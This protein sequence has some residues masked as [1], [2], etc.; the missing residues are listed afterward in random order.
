[1]TPNHEF[2]PFKVNK[3]RF[4][5]SLQRVLDEEVVPSPVPGAVTFRQE[6]PHGLVLGWFGSQIGQMELIIHLWRVITQHISH[7]RTERRWHFW[8]PV[9]AGLFLLSFSQ[10]CGLFSSFSSAAVVFFLEEFRISTFWIGK[11]Q[12]GN[13]GWCTFDS[14][15]FSSG[16]KLPYI[17]SSNPGAQNNDVLSLKVKRDL[18]RAVYESFSTTTNPLKLTWGEDQEQWED[19]GLSA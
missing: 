15:C 13:K 7:S 5:W 12:E 1:M 3:Q 10:R 14:V 16:T 19:T 6:G 8:Q 4:G 9:I 11:Q 18:L 2:T 17:L